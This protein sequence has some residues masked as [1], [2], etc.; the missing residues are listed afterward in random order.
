MI[1]SGTL[2]SFTLELIIFKNKDYFNEN[3]G[4][5]YVKILQRLRDEG[6]LELKKRSSPLKVAFT[7]K[8]KNFQIFQNHKLT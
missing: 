3:G 4:F 8:Q 6:L 7:T 5:D 1:T 2:A